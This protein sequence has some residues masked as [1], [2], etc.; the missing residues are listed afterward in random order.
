MSPEA[1]KCLGELLLPGERSSSRYEVMKAGLGGSSVGEYIIM[2]IGCELED[3]CESACCL[4]DPAALA[5]TTLD[6]ETNPPLYEEPIP[7]EF[8]YVNQ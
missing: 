7:V 2:P 1:A 3:I 5:P 4:R 6:E 8:T